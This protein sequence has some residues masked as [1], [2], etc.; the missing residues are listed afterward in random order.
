VIVHVPQE[1]SRRRGA[2][3]RIDDRESEREI[4]GEIAIRNATFAV[5]RC[6]QR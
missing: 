6:R 4:V 2:E 3:P 1:I 5:L